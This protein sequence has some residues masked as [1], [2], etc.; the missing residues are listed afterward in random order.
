VVSLLIFGNQLIT[1]FV[2]RHLQDRP[3]VLTSLVTICSG[4]KYSFEMAFK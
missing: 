4:Q 2:Q 1:G 3:G